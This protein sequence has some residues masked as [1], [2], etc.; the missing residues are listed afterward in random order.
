MEI[1]ENTAKL[2]DSKVLGGAQYYVAY[3]E[4]RNAFEESLKGE[5]VVVKVSDL[6]EYRKGLGLSQRGVAQL[7]GVAQSVVSRVELGKMTTGSKTSRSIEK[8]LNIKLVEDIEKYWLDE[9]KNMKKRPTKRV[10]SAEVRKEFI[11][12][13]QE[14]A[15]I[16]DNLDLF[17]QKLTLVE[18]EIEALM[19]DREE[20]ERELESYKVTKVGESK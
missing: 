7:A 17:R 10:V 19:T 20:I 5:P 3:D 9:Q 6:R 12:L 16:D 8:A 18:N 14:L 2:E 15:I 11:D 4:P 1:R 13:I